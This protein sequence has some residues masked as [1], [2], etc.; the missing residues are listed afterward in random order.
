MSVYAVTEVRFDEGK[1]LVIQAEMGPVIRKGN[2]WIAAPKLVDVIKVVD[3]IQAGDDVFTMFKIRGK[4]TPGPKLKIIVLPSGAEGV[5]IDG[6]E[7]K[8]M[9]LQDLPKF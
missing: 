9:T 6:P 2:E 8:G 7:V 1:K 4:Y 3:A 5:A